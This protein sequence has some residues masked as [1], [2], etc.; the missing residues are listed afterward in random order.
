MDRRMD[1]GSSLTSIL[2]PA[3]CFVLFISLQLRQLV[4]KLELTKKIQLASESKL[5]VSKNIPRNGIENSSAVFTLRL[6]NTPCTWGSRASCLSFKISEKAIG[7]TP[8]SPGAK[9]ISNNWQ[10]FRYAYQ[11]SLV[12]LRQMV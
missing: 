2:K 6:S 11:T 7:Q 1:I 10:S 3:Q 12:N 5:Q 8:L 4:H 9:G